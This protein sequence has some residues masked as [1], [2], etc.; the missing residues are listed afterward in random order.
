MREDRDAPSGISWSHTDNSPTALVPLLNQYKHA[1]AR[2]R[3]LETLTGGLKLRRAPWYIHLIQL[4]LW[5]APFIIALPFII[6]S[7][8]HLWNEY[9]VAVIYGFIQGT[10]VLSLEIIGAIIRYR[11]LNID[12]A[13]ADAQLDDEESVD[14]TPGSCCTSETFDFIFARKRLHSLILHP[15]ISGLVAFSAC[16]LLQPSIMLESLHVAGVVVVSVIGW[17]TFCSAHYS[18]GV[19]PPHEMAT[20]R[21]TDPLDLRFVTRPFYIVAIGAIFIPLR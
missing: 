11:C 15:L 20:Y 8:P 13:G 1:L 10:S 16:F 21:P 3:L 18:L 7:T 19:A 5:I 9:Y 2:R 4:T 14:F 17:Y 6:I 12:N